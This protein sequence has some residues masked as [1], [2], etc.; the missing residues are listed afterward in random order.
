MYINDPIKKKTTRGEG[1]RGEKRKKI[2][3]SKEL[4]WIFREFIN[5][6]FKISFVYLNS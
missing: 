6:K 1:G 4:D 2:G 3:K 5:S